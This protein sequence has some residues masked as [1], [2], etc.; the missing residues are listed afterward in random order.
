MTRNARGIVGAAVL[1]VDGLA[2]AS[3][4]L[5]CAAVGWQPLAWLGMDMEQV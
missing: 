2:A 5:G 3:I 4:L 1:L